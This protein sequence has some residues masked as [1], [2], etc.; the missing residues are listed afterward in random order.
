[1]SA[2]GDFRKDFTAEPEKIPVSADIIIAGDNTYTLYVNGKLIGQGNNW[3]VAQGYC[4]ELT[5]QAG[6]T[7]VF[8]VAVQNGGTAPNPAALITAISVNYND[9]TS[10]M[11]VSDDSWRA[12]SE[13]AGF[14]NPDFNDSTWP[15]AVVVGNLNSPP[16]SPNY[17]TVPAP[18][19]C[20]K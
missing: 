16:W 2:I 13:T 1:M 4:V 11:I 5:P 7:T 9:G 12:N 10:S 8:A 3:Q 14:E 15:Y 18:V 6:C 19:K 17:P 20:Q